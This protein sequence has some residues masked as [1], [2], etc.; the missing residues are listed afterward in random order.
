MHAPRPRSPILLTLAALLTLLRFEWA[1]AQ[2]N[3]TV[4]SSD[5]SIV[6]SGQGTG[7]ALFCQYTTNGTIIAGQAGCYNVPSMCAPSAAM[8]QSPESTAEFKF[9]GSAIYITA[10]LLSIS[11]IYTI[12]LDGQ[13]TDVDGVRPS[14]AFTCA[15]LFSSSSELDPTVEHTIRLSI[16]GP[17][18]NRNMT[19]D[20]AGQ[21][22]VF[23][24][25]NFIYTVPEA[26]SA[27]NA[28]S[29]DT[30]TD[31]A[32]APT[33]STSASSATSTNTNTDSSPAP[34][35]STSAADGLSMGP[36]GG[37]KLAALSALLGV[38]VVV[39]L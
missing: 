10:L 5:D 25:V 23:G 2:T 13:S 17:S 37:L 29:T 21:S 16:K 20:P 30:N 26:S 27:S 11:P 18:P 14:R 7:D 32:A 38:L 9:R 22:T 19:V 3:I 31:A 28:T 15:P 24:L 1:L 12:T 6:Y 36:N 33:T 35:T 8:G 39:S 4:P 34:T